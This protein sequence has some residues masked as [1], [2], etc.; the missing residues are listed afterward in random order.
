MSPFFFAD[1]VIPEDLHEVACLSTFI[2]LKVDSNPRFMKESRG[3]WTI[4][5]PSP[6]DSITIGLPSGEQL[7]C[8]GLIQF[9]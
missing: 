3:S 5:I 7:D 8:R 2:R 1:F 4:G 6:P 9:D